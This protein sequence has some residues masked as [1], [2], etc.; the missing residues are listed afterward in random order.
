[1][2]FCNQPLNIWD[3]QEYDQLARTLATTGEYAFTPGGELTSLRPPLYPALVAGVY[4]IAGPGNVAPVRFVQALLSLTTAGVLVALGRLILSHRGTLWLTGLFCFYPSLLGFN[5]LLLTETLFTFL[6]TVTCYFS[7]RTMVSG[8]VHYALL[9][10][11]GLGLAA[12]TRSIV[13]L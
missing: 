1:L 4:A 12:L 6:L 9:T 2:V 13:W 3:E 5:N 11:I 8:S 7:I 10:G